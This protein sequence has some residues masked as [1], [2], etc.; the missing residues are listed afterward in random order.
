MIDQQLQV[1]PLPSVILGDH[2]TYICRVELDCC[3]TIRQA[4]IIGHLLNNRFNLDGFRIYLSSTTTHTIKNLE[5]TKAIYKYKVGNYHIVFNRKVKPLENRAIKSWLLLHL[6][7]NWDVIGHLDW[8]MHMQDIKE[9]DTL[10]IGWKG[11]KKPPREVYRFGNQDEMIAEFED[12]K[13]YILKAMEKYRK[14]K[15]S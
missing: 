9:T 12:N 11:R 4:K 14:K 10:R 2:Y 7:T 1:N 13:N 6:K 8:W 5:L 3:F 15:P